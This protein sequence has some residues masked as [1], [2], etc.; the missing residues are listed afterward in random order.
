MKIAG[1]TVLLLATG[2]LA[3]PGHT[4]E[5]R[6]TVEVAAPPEEVWHLISEFCAIAEWHPAIGDCA[7]SEQDGA[8]MRTLTTTDGGV[9]VERRV[10]YS[11]EG[12]SYTYEIVEGPLPVAD[13]VSTLA[14]MAGANG[15]LITWSGEFAADGAED[16][17]AVE[18]ISGIYRTGLAALKNSAPL[19]AARRALSE[20]DGAMRAQRRGQ[21]SRHLEPFGG[22][23][24]GAD[25]QAIAV[26]AQHE[27]AVGARRVVDR[28]P[29]P[30]GL[31]T[32]FPRP[33]VGLDAAHRQPGLIE[34]DQLGAPAL[35]VV[36]AEREV[37]QQ[38][39]EAE[40]AG[41]RPGAGEREA[42]A[43]RGARRHDPRHQRVE[44]ARAER[45]VRVEHGVEP[46]GRGGG[47]RGCGRH[48]SRYSSRRP[49]R[50]TADRG[51]GLAPG[52]SGP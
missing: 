5:V 3:P 41:H 45:A 47:R 22:G 12:M 10:Q 17:Q 9:L 27:L 50:P 30:I 26:R 14:V 42:G 4:L 23:E 15:S 32:P 31:Q 33:P 37:E 49:P 19:T 25:H 7:R 46:D 44:A 34:P 52:S 13:Y 8:L 2:L 43:D 29:H 11:D 51:R 38:H 35:A 39:V 24:E 21:R 20:S 40:K 6:Q 1:P 28:D 16:D 36:P 48:G 18:V